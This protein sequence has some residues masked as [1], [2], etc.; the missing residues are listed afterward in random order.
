MKSL[1]GGEWGP[2]LVLGP[3][4]STPQGLGG[5][6][7]RVKRLPQCTDRAALPQAAPREAQ[8]DQRE[9]TL[10]FWKALGG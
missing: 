5:H 3:A 8:V 4:P 9:Q 7:P 6:G 2:W 1:L 10:S